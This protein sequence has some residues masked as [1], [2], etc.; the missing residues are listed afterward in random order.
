[1]KVTYQSAVL[2]VEDVA[3]SRQF[4]EGV[5]GQTVEMD[6]GANVG[7]KGGFAI[8][9]VDS[10]NQVVFGEADHV[11]G[12]LG[13]DNV[14]LYFE[15]ANLEDVQ[16]ALAAAAIPVVQP[17][18]EQPWGQRALRVYDPDRHLVEIAEPMA[19]VVQRLLKAGQPAATVSERTMMPLEI[20]QYV[21]EH[22]QF[23]PT[24]SSY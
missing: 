20:V 1:M 9:Q 6:F 4:Y 17:L 14:E 19:A 21:A 13:R 18:H 5:L 3:R 15:A 7:Y 2:F 16:Q 23:P 11:T 24:P 8:W 22:G 12:P 10:V